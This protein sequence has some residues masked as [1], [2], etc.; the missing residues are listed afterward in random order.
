MKID[1]IDSKKKSY[2]FIGENYVLYIG[3]SINTIP[4]KHHAVQIAIGINKG[5]KASV[6]DNWMETRAI[7]IDKDQIHQF[8]GEDQWNILLLMEAEMPACKVIRS[9]WLKEKAFQEL[10]FNEF[11]ESVDLITNSKNDLSS[12]DAK[13][14]YRSM[15]LAM[16]EDM[17]E[18]DITDTRVIQA[19][20]HIKQRNGN[21]ITVSE[22]AFA[23]TISPSR[24]MHLFKAQ[25]GIPIRRYILF[26]KVKEAVELIAEGK[27]FTIAAHQ[28]GF[29]DS[30][31]LA[32]T[33]KQMYGMILSDY[34]T[35]SSY[36]QL[37][38]DSE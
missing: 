23:V 34:F 13:N 37:L 20:H 24:L 12:I 19:I 15:I 5:F 22:L 28:A 4:H 36:I 6:N 8:N 3:T 26:E 21:P 9:K 18:Q 11:K 30:A 27:S 33:F 31:H 35:I 10:D 17:P 14:V 16:T 7:I 38:N 29:S 1:V 25:T 2:I 32:R